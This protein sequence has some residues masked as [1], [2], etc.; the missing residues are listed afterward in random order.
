[1]QF[2]AV[3]DAVLRHTHLVISLYQKAALVP[4]GGCKMHSY[5]WEKY[6]SILAVEGN[7]VL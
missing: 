4:K 5:V 1:V 3:N 6:P 7:Y 2:R